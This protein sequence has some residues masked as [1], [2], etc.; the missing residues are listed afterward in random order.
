MKKLI[1][2]LIAAFILNVLPA[3]ADLGEPGVS[4]LPGIGGIREIGIFEQSLDKRSDIAGVPV[5]RIYDLIV[6][7]DQEY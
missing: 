4:V 7:I 3:Q 6:G 5:L 2:V 1:A